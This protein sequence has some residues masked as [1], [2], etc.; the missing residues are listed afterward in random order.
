MKTTKVLGATTLAGTLLFTGVGATHSN[1]AHAD[2]HEDKREFTLPTPSEWQQKHD[3]LLQA[4]KE[5]PN[6]G[7]EGGGPGAINSYDNS[8]EEYVHNAIK[9]EKENGS[10]DFKIPKEGK[11]YLNGQN[12]DNS[13]NQQST[14]NNDQQAQDQ[15]TNNTVNTQN[16]EQQQTQNTNNNTTAQTNNQ[17]QAKALPETGGESSNTTIVT[18]IASVLLAAGSLLTFKRFSKTN[19]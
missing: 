7:G 16:N 8:Y 10:R 3:E 2:T 9:G 1:E 4:R 15:T 14:Q 19:K 5:H 12:N 13:N 17:E 18:I 6:Q 11:E